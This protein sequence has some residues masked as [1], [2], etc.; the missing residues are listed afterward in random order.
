MGRYHFFKC[1]TIFAN[2]P[3]IDKILIGPVSVVGLV[4]QN[5]IDH[6]WVLLVGDVKASTIGFANTAASSRT[7][8]VLLSHF[9]EY[10]LQRAAVAGER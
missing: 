4:S 5:N 3:S 1:D 8:T 7:V 2:Y 6:H 9:K 10:M